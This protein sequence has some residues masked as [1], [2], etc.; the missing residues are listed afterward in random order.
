MFELPALDTLAAKTELALYD[1]CRVGD[2]VR[3]L[4]RVPG[5]GGPARP[6]N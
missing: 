1:L 5:R 6:A 4:A 3:I 2:D